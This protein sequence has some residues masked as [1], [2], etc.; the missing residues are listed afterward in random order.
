MIIGT[1][2]K[3]MAQKSHAHWLAHPMKL[4]LDRQLGISSN[5]VTANKLP[6]KICQGKLST[7]Q[8]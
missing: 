6:R 5:T 7:T 2:L 4:E 1:D 8:Q 3:I